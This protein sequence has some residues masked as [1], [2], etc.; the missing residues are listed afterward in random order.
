MELLLAV[1]DAL[2]AHVADNI[3]LD[4]SSAIAL[5]IQDSTHAH[6]ADGVALTLDVSLVVA[7]SLHAH[8]ADGVVLTTVFALTVADSTHGHTADN[9]VL[10][11]STF[12]ESQLLEILAYIQENLMVPTA[13]EIAAAVWA[14]ASGALVKKLGTNRFVTDPATGIATLYDDDGVTPLQQWEMYEDAAGTI[15]YRGRGAELRIPI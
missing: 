13:A 4:T 8:Q 9:V 7:E 6:A 14:S 11:F 1:A 15:A 12:T 5:T 2:H 3:A 10:F